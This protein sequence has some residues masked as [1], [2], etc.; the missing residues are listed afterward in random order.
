MPP[1]IV[2][3]ETERGFTVIELVVAVAV[4]GILAGLAVPA[5]GP[6]MSGL[7]AK[8]AAR[9]LYSSFQQAK[10][11]AVKDNTRRAIVFDTVARRYHVC[12]D[13]G[14]DDDWTT[15]ADNTIEKTINLGDYGPNV[16]F[17]HG[18]ATTALHDAGFDDEVTFVTPNNVATLHPRGGANSGTVYIENT[19]NRDAYSIDLQ[20]SGVVLLRKWSGG[21][22]S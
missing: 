14:A 21:G 16:Q 13:S 17:G 8:S 10:V 11:G 19:R 20:A 9:D 22:W 18:L 4:A 12:S 2:P 5:F 6:W 3:R 15:L 1:R 7:K